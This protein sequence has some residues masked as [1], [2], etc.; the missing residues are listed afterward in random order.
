MH[1]LSL[2]TE[3]LQELTVILADRIY[4]LNQ[5]RLTKPFHIAEIANRQLDRAEN[6][7]QEV[8]TTFQTMA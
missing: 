4:E 3:Q 5:E 6:I 1:N 7:M 8:R 2:T